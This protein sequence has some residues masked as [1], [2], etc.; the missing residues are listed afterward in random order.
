MQLLLFFPH[1]DFSLG[2][3]ALYFGKQIVRMLA[4]RHELDDVTLSVN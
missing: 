3:E 1:L 4:V 2:E